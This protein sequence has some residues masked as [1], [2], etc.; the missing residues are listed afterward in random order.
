MKKELYIHIGVQKTGTSAIQSFMISNREKLAQDYSCLYPDFQSPSFNGGTTLNHGPFFRNNN[1]DTIL[2]SL[3]EMISYSNKK[4]I[5]KIIL[6]WEVLYTN[7]QWAE[8]INEA[9]KDQ[10]DIRCVVIAYVRRQDHWLESAWKQMGLKD[11]NF[12]S[13]HDYVYK[14]HIMWLDYFDKWADIFGKN[15][16]IVHAYENEQLPDGLISDFFKILNIDIKDSNWVQPSSHNK[17]DNF[18]FHRDV[19][20]ILQLNRDF[21]K[22]NADNRLFNF[23]SEYL[24]DNYKKKPFEKYSLLSPQQRIELLEKYEPMNK[25]IAQ[26]YMGKADGKVFYEPMPDPNEPWEPYEGLTVEKIVPIFTQV[27]FNMDT[28]Y[29]KKFRNLRQNMNRN[30]KKME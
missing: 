1:S 24:N 29:K 12:D 2:D 5:K 10:R 30:H 15:N 6:S 7:P 22:D 8:I 26:K 23:F 21:Y 11:K 9:V 17:N 14:Y 13:I 19:I 18:G 20:E 16:F 4:N 25:I 27:L 28:K 3:H